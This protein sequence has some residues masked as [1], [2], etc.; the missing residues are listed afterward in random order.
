M[1]TTNVLFSKEGITTITSILSVAIV[2][3]KSITSHL[4]KPIEGF[5]RLYKKAGLSTWVARLF[6]VQIATKKLPEITPVGW[7]ALATG[8]SFFFIASC[9][10]S[11]YVI[12][13][14]RVPEG[15]T[16][17]TLKATNED[18]A[19]STSS[20]TGVALRPSWTIT[21]ETCKT[22]KSQELVDYGKMSGLL[23]KFI[24][25]ALTEKKDQEEIKKS[26]TNF[27]HNQGI[28]SFLLMVLFIV[29]TWFFISL[30]MTAV[31]TNKVRAVILKEQQEAFNYLT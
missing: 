5:G 22:G 4:T 7:A 14:N 30:V 8:L 29:S 23:H 10:S 31:Y 27:S 26:I 12:K 13:I 1:Q 11:Y 19:I 28:I 20:A 21:S 18:F 17:L 16:W 15:S 3:L 25:D 24:C 2:I 9:I 6:S